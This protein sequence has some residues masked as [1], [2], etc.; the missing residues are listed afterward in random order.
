MSY[1][2]FTKVQLKNQ[3]RIEAWLAGVPFRENSRDKHPQVPDLSLERVL[4]EF[5]P[6]D[7]KGA[8]Q[9][10]TPLDMA[11][12]ALSYIAPFE[13]ARILDPC[14]GIGN[15]L[16][17][18]L[19]DKKWIHVDAYEMEGECVRVGQKLFPWVRRHHAI[20]FDHLD[21]IEGRYDFVVMN[22]PFGTA[23]GMVPGE[24]MAQGRATR[25]EHIFMELA[26]RAL[27][28][29]GYAVMIVPSQGE[30]TPAFH[31]RTMPKKMVPWFEPRAKLVYRDARLPGEFQFTQINVE[32]LVFQRTDYDAPVVLEAEAVAAIPTP[33]AEAEPEPI[34]EAPPPILLKPVPAHNLGFALDL[35]GRR[36]TWK[37]GVGK[38]V[39][40]SGNG[41]TLFVE[42]IW[43]GKHRMQTVNITDI[44]PNR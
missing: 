35:I 23:R 13:G 11:S 5:C 38:V 15:L 31:E 1:M 44:Q 21:A 7:V 34:T 30:R 43:S 22:P 32:A 29:D 40:V 25:S 37:T 19:P 9:F 12:Q 10:Y 24:T 4:E 14:C 42:T 39:N 28:P 41:Q 20:P 27:K 16:Y 33:M 17:P 26:V 6:P 8:G 18:F 36:V 3:E 2:K